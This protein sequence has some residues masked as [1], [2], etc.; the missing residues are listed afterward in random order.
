MTEL[1]SYTC[2]DEDSRL[3]HRGGDH[4]MD[5]AREHGATGALVRMIEEHRGLRMAAK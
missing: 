1:Y 4:C 3:A 5:G 2:K